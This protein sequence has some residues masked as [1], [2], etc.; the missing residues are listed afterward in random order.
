LVDLERELFDQVVV[1]VVGD[2]EVFAVFGEHAD[3]GRGFGKVWSDKNE[4]PTR[5][6]PWNGW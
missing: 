1:L 2:V 3:S 4:R 6:Y 5:N